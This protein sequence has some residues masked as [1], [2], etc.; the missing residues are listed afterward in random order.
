MLNRSSLTEEIKDIILNL[1]GDLLE[2]YGIFFNKWDYI[3]MHQLEPCTQM[4]PQNQKDINRRLDNIMLNE[5]L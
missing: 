1:E 5:K 2:L 3:E 4:I